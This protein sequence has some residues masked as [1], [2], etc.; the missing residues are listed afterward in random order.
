LIWEL[1]VRLRRWFW[2][3][4]H[5]FPEEQKKRLLFFVTGSDRVPINGL[6]SLHPQF[7]VAKN[8]PHSERLPTAHTCF[9]YLLLPS[10]RDKAALRAR[11]ETAIDNAEGFGLM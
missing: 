6:A 11:L 8:G 5:A 2:E 9:N 3:L 4:V 10:Y 7:V 1:P